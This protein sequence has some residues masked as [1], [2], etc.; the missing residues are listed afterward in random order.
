MKTFMKCLLLLPLF[1]CHL[2]VAQKVS[3]NI[4]YGE[5]TELPNETP[6][7]ELINDEITLSVKGLMN[8]NASTYVASFHIVQ[9][10]ETAEATDVLM[11]SRIQKLKS[12]LARVGIDTSTVKTDMISF[13][14]R[15]DISILN[16]IFSKSYNEVPDGFELQKNVMIRYNNPSAI[17][18]IVTAAASAEI[19][20]LVKVDY[21]LNDVTKHYDSLRRQCVE[22]IKARIKTYEALGIRFDTLKR[23][24]ADNFKTILPQQRY[25]QYEAV[26]RPSLSAVKRAT[27]GT[28][29]KFRSA[30]ISP[31]RYYQGVDYN[32]FDV[33]INPVVDEPMVQLTYEIKVRFFGL[34]PEIKERYFFVANDR[35]VETDVPGGH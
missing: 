26:A 27:E 5:R 33:V 32:E 34:K 3:G 22:A 11:T 6:N 10:G 1:L 21:F 8:M 20:D 17:D 13:V 16:K 2:V 14:P 12:A 23:S 9:V 28:S 30:D 4:N 15:Y 24:L 29:A 25:G 18:A 31:S 19:Y 7:A 35:K